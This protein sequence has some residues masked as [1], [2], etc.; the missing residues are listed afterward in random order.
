MAPL[1][2]KKGFG[3]VAVGVAALA[4]VTFAVCERQKVTALESQQQDL[5]ATVEQAGR[6][7]EAQ[8]GQSDALA[9]IA[10]QRAQAERPA[11]EEA[12]PSPAEPDP[13]TAPEPRPT[14]PTPE[15]Y[16]ARLGGSFAS[17]PF[18]DAWGR[19]ATETVTSRLATDGDRSLRSI[20]CRTSMCRLVTD[21]AGPG[22]AGQLIRTVLG[23]PGD[24][25]WSG[26]Y[27][28]RAEDGPDGR[29]QRVTYLFRSGAPLPSIAADPA[30]AP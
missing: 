7:A 2:A 27:F 29:P 9:R 8:R 20:E 15:V 14:P 10:L 13:A 24:E 1:R 5:M 25:V 12:P 28:S 16:L 18:D 3:R 21:D 26:A 17:E 6:T 22:P 30:D 23:Q 4:A 11:P 19:R